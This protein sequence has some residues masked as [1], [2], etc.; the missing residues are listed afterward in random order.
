LFY[1]ALFIRFRL[2]LYSIR[3]RFQNLEFYADK[4]RHWL[5]TYG[6]KK[7]AADYETM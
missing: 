2:I 6:Q 1:L 3:Y 7:R 5:W 4:W